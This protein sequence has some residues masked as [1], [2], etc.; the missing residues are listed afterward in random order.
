MSKTAV[1]NTLTTPDKRLDSASIIR[2]DLLLTLPGK[3]IFSDVAVIHSLT[4]GAV[5]T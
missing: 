5:R 2:Q 1:V 4:A 3:R